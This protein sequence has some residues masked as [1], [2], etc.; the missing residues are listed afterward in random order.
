M[1]RSDRTGQPRRCHG[2]GF[3]W[4]ALLPVLALPAAGQERADSGAFIVRLGRDT[5]SVERY[6][7]SGDTLR[8]TSV[9]R[10]PQTAVR[11]FAAV[12]GPGGEVRAFATAREG[13]AL[14]FRPVTGGA[15]PL[16]GGFYTPFQLAVQR[17]M[18]A[19]ADSVTI[20]LLSGQEP[21]PIVVRR[22]DAR[23]FTL[24]NQFGAAMRATTDTRG[25][26]NALD[27]AGGTT[28][29]RLP[30]LDLDAMARQ[31]RAQDAAGTGLGPLSPLDSPTVRIAGAR[32]R[33]TYSRPSLR[34]RPLAM[35][36]PN[37][38]VW[39]TG[40]NNAT[41]LTTDRPLRFGDTTVP[42]GTYSLFTLPSAA[43]WKLII[44]RQTGQSG[45]DHDA[46]RDLARIDMA[47]ERNAPHTERFTIDVE[48][49]AGGGVVRLRWGSIRASAPFAVGNDNDS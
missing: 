14:Q 17:A 1:K 23:T 25:R 13:D 37:D 7:R 12:F 22:V 21:L 28:V 24:P 40:A 38:Q 20:Q 39:R 6:V 42:A 15:I 34:G 16:A 45:L 4:L 36:V 2:A 46:A 31:F 41:E 47:V 49:S 26:I 5:L 32:I 29:Q 27:V 43:G 19:E 3:G 44:N 48:Q 11:Q 30:W 10:S 9:A 18:A 35:L 8:V 33:V